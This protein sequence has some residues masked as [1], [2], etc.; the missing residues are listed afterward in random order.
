MG[1]KRMQQ[2]TSASNIPCKDSQMT[3]ICGEMGSDGIRKGL[4]VKEKGG[5]LG[6]GTPV[7]KTEPPEK[8]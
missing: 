5:H 1:K 7:I 8:H 3:A 4:K 6:Y 2:P